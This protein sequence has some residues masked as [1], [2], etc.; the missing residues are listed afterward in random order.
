MGSWAD[1]LTAGEVS[2]Q[3]NKASPAS[4]MFMAATQSALAENP[5]SRQVNFAGLFGLSPE[6]RPHSG[7][8]RLVLCGGTATSMPPP[9]PKRF[10]D[11]LKCQSLIIRSPS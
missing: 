6:V 7:H 8:L 10:R 2:P 9:H 1:A 5:H 4:L 11:G 3:A